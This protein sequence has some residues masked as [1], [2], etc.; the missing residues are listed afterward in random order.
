MIETARAAAVS[1]NAWQL[2]PPI[3]GW[4][5]L[6][7]PPRNEERLRAVAAELRAR[8]LDASGA[9][10]IRP[11]RG[12]RGTRLLFW[13]PAGTGKTMAARVLGHELRRGVIEADL[14]SVLANERW[15]M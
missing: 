1:A 5:D 6:V 9:Q 8:F 10:P 14:T 7:L 2:L 13:G 3:D 15:R 12:K 4:D 11:S